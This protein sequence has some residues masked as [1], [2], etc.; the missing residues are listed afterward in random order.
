MRVQRAREA[1]PPGAAFFLYAE[2]RNPSPQQA[3]ARPEND[4]S[5]RRR[6]AQALPRW[7]PR[8]STCTGAGPVR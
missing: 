8:C 3:S 1:A 6:M 4:A 5:S 7:Q 2:D